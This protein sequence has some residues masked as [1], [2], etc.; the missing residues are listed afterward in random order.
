MVC[1][2][3]SD[4]VFDF[5]RDP[6]RTYVDGDWIKA[7]GTT[8]GADDG[9]GVAAQ[10]AILDSQTIAHGNLECFFTTDEEM[11]LNGA[12]ALRPG[13]LSGNCL[14]N[15]DSE[16]EGEFYIGCAGGKTTRASFAFQTVEAPGD[17][18]WFHV[19]AGGLSGGHSGGEIHKGLGNANKILTRY[20]WT[21]AAETPL[22]IAH[23]DG[24]NLG[25]AIAREASAT[26]GVPFDRK[27]ATIVLLNLLQA[28][29]EAELKATDPAVKLSL[30]SA[31]TPQ[32]CLAPAD[33]Q[34]LLN[35][36]YAC[37]HGVAGMSV[38]M[39]GLVETS[40]N[41]AS[42]KMTGN[43][44]VLVTTSQRSAADSLK[45]DIANAVKAVFDLAGAE[46]T[47]TEGYP[48][49]KPNPDSPIL[50]AAEAVYLKCFG[51]KPEIKAI[52][53]GLECGLFREKYPEMDM[54]SCGPTILGA[55]SPD[56][57]LQISSVEKWW[58]FLVELLENIPVENKG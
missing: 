56:E 33:G 20:L 55:H 57:R 49:W 3:N 37:P 47:C 34:R 26:A 40:T 31:E 25:N 50:K 23:I 16:E 5:E 7:R 42:V 32:T 41:L 29:L 45:H 46:V 1:E 19:A 54:I 35:A 18:F 44:A 27:E 30:Q 2:K 6:I 21:L 4:T 39:P 38:D 17:Y 22:R 36:L 8:L 52:H 28:Q 51:Q 11:G 48:G 43:G 58:T 53:A 14:I 10:L 9:I 24:G 12:Y 13:F 15:L